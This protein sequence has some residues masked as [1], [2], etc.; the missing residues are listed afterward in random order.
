MFLVLGGVER[1]FIYSIVAQ[2]RS[3]WNKPS[4]PKRPD[5]SQ[6]LPR[7]LQI[8]NVMKLVTLADVRE[9][10]EKHL[11]ADYRQK[12]TWQHVAAQLAEAASG[13]D[14]MDVSIALRLALMLERVQCQPLLKN[15]AP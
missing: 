7:P 11:P 5:W 2:P 9:R 4:R 1:A 13:V 14:I 10:V 12:E 15:P 3:Y 6:P 8:P